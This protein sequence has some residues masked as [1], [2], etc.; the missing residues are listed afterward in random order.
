MF[1]NEVLLE[2]VGWICCFSS[3]IFMS[4]ALIANL[5]YAQNVYTNF[6]LFSIISPVNPFDSRLDNILPLDRSLNT[7]SNVFHYAGAASFF[8]ASAIF[9]WVYSPFRKIKI[10]NT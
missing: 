2:R 9:F 1:K 5:L 10:K 6:L 4:A 8:M 7:L 3:I